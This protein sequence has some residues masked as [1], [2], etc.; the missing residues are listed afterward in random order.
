MLRSGRRTSTRGPLTNDA[1]RRIQLPAA[2]RTGATIC[3]GVDRRQAEKTVK[4]SGGG[5]QLHRD[6]WANRAARAGTAPVCGDTHESTKGVSGKGKEHGS[7][8]R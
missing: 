2:I 7:R 4:E 1:P 5:E 3:D 8:R 6:R